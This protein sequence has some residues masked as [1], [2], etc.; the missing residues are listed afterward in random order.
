VANGAEIEAPVD[1]ATVERD[2]PLIVSVGRLERYKGPTASSRRS[3]NWSSVARAQDCASVGK[4][5]TSLNCK[6]WVNDLACRRAPPSGLAPRNA[7]KWAPFLA[8]AS[9][10]ALLRD[11][12]A[13]P[14]A[15]LEAISLGRPVL[16]S[17]T[18]G[19]AEMA[20]RGLLHGVD[21]GAQPKQQIDEWEP[22]HEQSHQ[23]LSRR[24]L[25]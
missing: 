20:A 5:R 3:A 11:Y 2:A 18:S 19:F 9:V 4:E 12:E 23:Y 7:S 24:S 1:V 13:H 21:P 14:V 25:C 8:R 15:A 17:N 22:M 16:A 6:D 10:G